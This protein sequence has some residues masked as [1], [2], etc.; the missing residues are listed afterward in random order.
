MESRELFKLNLFY[1]VK[2]FRFIMD[3]TIM[4]IVRVIEVLTERAGIECEDVT[5]DV[6][7]VGGAILSKQ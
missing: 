5:S 7:D 1:G 6:T 2:C 3:A 4:T